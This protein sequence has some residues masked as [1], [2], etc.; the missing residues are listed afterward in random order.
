MIIDA[1]QHL[2]QIGRNGHE[3]PTPDYAAIYGDYVADDLKRVTAECGVT[4]TVLVQSQPNDTD[5][6]WMLSV[7]AHES[8]IKGVVGWADLTA[9]NAPDRI[10]HLARQPKF[11]GLRP[12][13]QGM[14]DSEWILRSEVQ[15]AL[16]ALMRLG[17]TFDALVVPRH[18]PALDRLARTRPGLRIV[19]D[20]G[21][22]PPIAQSDANANQVWRDDM[23]AL[24][25][26]ENVVCKLSGL[27]TEASPH[28]GLERVKPYADHL[29]DVFGPNRLMWGSDWPVIDL[30]ISYRQWFDWTHAWLDGLGVPAHSGAL[31]AIMGG[32]AAAF[33]SLT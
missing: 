10:A 3:W 20:H 32:T 23:R 4:G 21:A 12:M 30:R 28:Q 8:L 33:Y 31:A 19:I 25:R 7:A 14:A 24:A 27:I 1:H 22:K 16:D 29:L 26:H 2:W 11:K 17:L 9:P 5:T 18:L 6:D 15:P 13:L